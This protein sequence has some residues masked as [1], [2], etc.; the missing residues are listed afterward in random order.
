MVCAESQL[1]SISSSLA[2]S[3]RMSLFYMLKRYAFSF[4]EVVI[5]IEELRRDAKVWAGGEYG[6]PHKVDTDLL[7]GPLLRP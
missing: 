3:V 5:R 2:A 4:Y 6:R 7:K 1:A